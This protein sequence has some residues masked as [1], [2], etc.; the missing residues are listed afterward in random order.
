MLNDC[1]RQQRVEAV[2]SIV[3]PSHL[4]GAV[5]LHV[6]DSETVS[7]F[8]WPDG[9]VF[10]TQGLMDRCTDGE[11]AAAIAHELGHVLGDG[12]VPAVAG[13]RGCD[14]DLDEEQRADHVGTELLLAGG[15]PPA[16][17]AAILRIV[18]ESGELGPGCRQSLAR[19]IRL[20]EEGVYGVSVTPAATA[21]GG[22]AVKRPVRTPDST[23]GP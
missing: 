8:S 4:R 13:L 9:R 5:A 6:L 20:I 18:M 10:V 1:Q 12:H 21:A 22:V 16:E 19:R 15:L 17:M 11:L 2:G 7:A 23:P 14:R 3:V